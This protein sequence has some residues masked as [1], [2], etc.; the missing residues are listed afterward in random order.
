MNSDLNKN[1]LQNDVIDSE[2]EN[3]WGNVGPEIFKNVPVEWN[4]IKECSNGHEPGSSDNKECVYIGGD[5]SFM[6]SIPKMVG[7]RLN[8]NY[9]KATNVLL[10]VKTKCNAVGNEN[11][12]IV[13]PDTDVDKDIPFV[14]PEENIPLKELEKILISDNREIDYAF[15]KMLNEVKIHSP[16]STEKAVQLL[17]LIYDNSEAFSKHDYDIGMAK[18]FEF[19][20]N[21]GDH[22]PIATKPHRLNPKARDFAFY[23]IDM[24]EKHGIIR[25]S[26]SP[27]A[28]PICV[29]PKP[30]SLDLRMCVDFRNL[31]LISVTDSYP[32]PRID[33]ITD[34]LGGMENISTLD[35]ASGYYNI[36]IRE[37]DIPKTAFTVSGK[38]LYEFLRLPFG[39]KNAPS[40][41]VRMM[42]ICLSD[43]IHNI[44]LCY[45]DDIIIF[46][47]TKEQHFERLEIVFKRLI[48]HGL[49]L[50]LKKCEFFKPEVFFLGHRISKNGFRPDET[51]LEAV[52]NYPCPTTVTELKGFLGLVGYYRRF[53]KSF[54]KIAD[55]LHR[56]LKKDVE[57]IN[58]KLPWNDA[59]QKAFELLKE[60]LITAPVLAFPDFSPDAGQF[61]LHTDASLLGLGAV[62]EQVQ[63]DGKTIKPVAFVNRSLT[64]AEKHVSITELE[65]GAV[66]FAFRK[67]RPY[68][69]GGKR[70]KLYTDHISLRWLLLNGLSHL[71][72]SKLIRWCLEL[73]EYDFEVIHRPG[74]INKVPDALSRAFSSIETGKDFGECAPEELMLF[75]YPWLFEYN[76]RSKKNKNFK[77]LNDQEIEIEIENTQGSTQK[78]DKNDIILDNDKITFDGIENQKLD[79]V[80][81][82]FPCMGN[83][84]ESDLLAIEKLRLAQKDDDFA[85]AVMKYLDDGIEC[86]DEIVAKKIARTAYQYFIEDGLLFHMHVSAFGKK[87]KVHGTFKQL[88]IPEN[89]REEVMCSE[90]DSI[91]GGHNGFHITFDRIQRKYFWLTMSQD[92]LDYI[93]SC[94][95]CQKVNKG[96]RN[97]KLTL[98]SIQVPN[99][100][101]DLVSMD[102]LY[103]NKRGSRHYGNKYCLVILD[104]KTKWLKVIPLRNQVAVTIARR[105]V[106]DYVCNFGIPKRLI[107]DQGSPLIGKV[108]TELF[109]I[110]GIHKSQ[111]TAFHPQ[112]D[113]VERYNRNILRMLRKY[114]YRMQHKWD[115]YVHLLAYAYNACVHSSTGESPF[116]LMYG[117]NPAIP[118]CINLPEF[119]A[120]KT[121][122]E[123]SSALYAVMR[124]VWKIAGFNNELALEAIKRN[125]D[126][127]ARQP[128]HLEVGDTV[129]I[130]STVLLTQNELEGRPKLEVPW[131]KFMIVVDAT[132][133]HTV[134]VVPKY[135]DNPKVWTFN[136]VAVK[137][138]ISREDMKKIKE[139][140]LKS[141]VRRKSTRF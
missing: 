80:A 82:D 131:A 112:S 8:I 102:I 28:S 36:K 75:V 121:N 16:L 141:I 37:C 11:M 76:L 32:L 122:V 60:M 1:V 51:K 127:H 123:Y 115:T 15:L 19:P 66:Q 26:D 105:F 89:F 17:K 101:M 64:P 10:N 44:L 99:E 92:I 136:R 9:V 94:D 100:P 126:K 135:V 2:N 12:Y 33:E 84:L 41:F 81:I 83:S 72:S 85:D 87:Q 42:D 137:K 78:V 62:L 134:K 30:R 117:R 103:I 132:N 91:F 31:N 50:K 5:P 49:K 59:C 77:Q 43:L 68:L 13:T 14:V 128:E 140:R 53:I 70:F 39:L 55:P 40:N 27:W 74:V 118:S 56:L 67:L 97:S 65:A 61:I 129:L 23:N 114:C 111:T 116:F 47:K 24:L 95:L 18:G 104:H 46:S 79:T 119:K 20:I 71:A 73:Q 25:K 45:I 93:M 133:S 120:C 106:D 98:K 139:E 69:I 130:D 22:A 107:T 113:N 52:K 29:V 110:L 138:Y 35:L 108:C 58:K 7:D 3:V 63:P 21:T 48:K 38:G 124:D 54:A 34:S 6:Y 88:Y 96:F 4:T 125:H 109:K 86:S 90:H 57:L